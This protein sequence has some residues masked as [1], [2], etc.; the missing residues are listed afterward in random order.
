MIFS[1]IP[2]LT[3]PIFKVNLKPL[4]WAF[5]L[6]IKKY[7]IRNCTQNSLEKGFETAKNRLQNRQPTQDKPTM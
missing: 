7:D 5:N 2:N 6:K 1:Q 3:S 4:Y